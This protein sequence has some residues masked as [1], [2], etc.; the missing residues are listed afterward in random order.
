MHDWQDAQAFADW[1]C[2]FHAPVCF[3]YKGHRWIGIPEPL[4]MA[5][6]PLE[7]FGRS[8]QPLE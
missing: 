2:E 1:L 3:I 5:A 8:L 6:T 7:W 4:G